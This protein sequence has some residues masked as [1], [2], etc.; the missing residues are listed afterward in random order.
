MRALQGFGGRIPAGA[1]AAACATLSRVE[2]LDSAQALRVIGAE[3]SAEIEARLVGTGADNWLQ[4]SGDP[5][6]TLVSPRPRPGAA[7][8]AAALAEGLYEQGVLSLGAHIPS[9]ACGARE[10]GRLLAAYD[11]VLPG[12]VLRADGGAFSR[13]MARRA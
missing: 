7:A 3:I 4:I 2:R 6:W 12:L 11:A 9:L 8:L 5:A 1:F 10:V 13:R